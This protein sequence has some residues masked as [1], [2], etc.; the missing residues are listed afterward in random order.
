MTRVAD[1]DEFLSDM[2]ARMGLSPEEALNL[3]AWIVAVPAD[4]LT[5]LDLLSAGE[6]ATLRERVQNGNNERTLM[7]WRCARAPQTPMSVTEEGAAW[8]L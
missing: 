4:R 3:A 5:S 8:L 7:L 6:Y 1:R 2:Q